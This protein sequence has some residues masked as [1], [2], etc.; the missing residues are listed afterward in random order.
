MNWVRK[1]ILRAFWCALTLTQ[2]VAAEDLSIQIAYV[3]KPIIIAPT[4]SNLDPRPLTEGLDGAVLAIEENKTTGKFLGQDFNLTALEIPPDG[5][6]TGVLSKALEDFDYLLLNLPKA[7]MLW[8]ADSATNTSKI[9]FNVNLDDAD[10]RTSACHKNLL[11]TLPSTAM[12]TD[13]LAQFAFKKKWTKWA[14]IAG[15]TPNDLARAASY[16]TSA[17]KFGIKIVGRKEWSFGGDMRRNAAQE[18]P[19]FTQSFKKH[20]MM[21]VADPRN[22]FARYVQYNTWIPRPLGGAAGIKP[23]AWARA[24]EQYGAV[25]LQNRFRNASG[26]QMRPI[27][28][29]SWA[30]VRSLGEAMNRTQSND[31]AELYSYLLSEKFALGGFKGRSL[32]FRSWNGQMRQ[33]VALAH[34]DAVVAMAPLEGFLHQR[35][36][37]DTLGFDKAESGCKA[38]DGE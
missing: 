31:P 14:L 34:N 6:A 19:L 17:R 13:A 16:E 3:H 30:A 26:R 35:N 32:S 33:P 25:Q 29:A 21:I 23:T 5:D 20:D 12:L 1:A 2:A 7:D 27:D 38:F 4:L 18:V 15:P 22:D 9:L 11:H 10:L 28:Y 24:V 8:L 36:E 37:L